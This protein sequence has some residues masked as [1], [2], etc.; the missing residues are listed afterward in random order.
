M[1]PQ[2]FLAGPAVFGGGRVIASPFQF[3]L[4]G[5]DNLQIVSAN[6]L[7]GVV[8]AVQGRRIDETG[9]LLPFAYVHTPHTD[10]S[11]KV[12]NFPLGR[13]ALLNLTVFASQGAPRV[14]QTYVSARLIR[15]L[16]ASTIMLGALLGGYVTGAQPLAYPGSPIQSS[17]ES[18]GYTMGVAGTTP[19]AGAEI[20]ELVPAAA[21]WELIGVWLNLMTSAAVPARRVILSVQIIGPRVVEAL[22]PADQAAASRWFY[23]FGQGDVALSDTTTARAQ[24]SLP[25]GLRLQAGSNFSTVTNNLD[26]GDQWDT[27][28][29]L[30]RERLVVSA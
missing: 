1:A 19:A 28:R 16:A 29:Y 25:V 5:D 27:P 21:D 15:G 23:T 17:F 14:G 3:A 9:Q 11:T 13:G 18:D 22:A 26:A 24:T 30:V 10:R 2:E 7:A 6:S 20:N 12:E 4:S 8:L